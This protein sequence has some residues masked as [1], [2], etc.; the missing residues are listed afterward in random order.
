MYQDVDEVEV[1]VGWK[2]LSVETFP[3]W[4]LSWA[5]TWGLVYTTTNISK[6][7]KTAWQSSTSPYI[8]SRKNILKKEKNL[9]EKLQ[10]CQRLITDAM[11][12]WTQSPWTWPV[13]SMKYHIFITSPWWNILW[14]KGLGQELSERGSKK[15]ALK[16][17]KSCR[18]KAKI[19]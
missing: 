19:N 2:G 8:K 13:S 9:K 5:S 11:Q 6:T 18:K 4:N 16:A 12:S 15:G 14:M 17:V 10:L 3:Q 1:A 7:K